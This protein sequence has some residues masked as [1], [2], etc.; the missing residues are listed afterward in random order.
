MF[1]PRVM[2]RIKA[3]LGEGFGW[4]AMLMAIIYQSVRLLPAGHPYTNP[5]NKGRF[6]VRHVIAEAAYNL[7]IK[8]E[9][10]D[11][12]VIFGI[13]LL[14]L[15]LL[16]LQIIFLIV[17]MMIAPAFAGF[18]AGIPGF[19]GLFATPNPTDDIAFMI[20]DQVFGIPG[21]YNSKFAPAAGAIPPFQVGLQTLFQYY[22][23]MILIV[24]VFI[25]LYYIVVTL[26]ETVTTGVPFGR[27]FNSIYAPF[28]LVLAIGLIVPLN[29]GM[30]C[31][32][33]ITLFS[34]KYGS[35]LATNGWILFANNVANPTDLRDEALLARP[36]L[37]NVNHI[38]KFMMIVQ[39]CRFAYEAYYNGTNAG[40]DIAN[41]P[42]A[43]P[44]PPPGPTPTPPPA[45]GPGIQPYYV[46]RLSSQLVPVPADWQAAVDFFNGE[47]IKIRFGHY[48]AANYE[49]HRGS[50]FPFCGEITVHTTSNDGVAGVTTGAEDLQQQFLRMIT[51]LWA[52]P[53]MQDFGERAT[54]AFLPI[55]GLPDPCSVD[56][57]SYGEA[58][59]VTTNPR[60]PPEEYKASMYTT[61]RNIFLGQVDS[62]YTASTS[63]AYAPAY[64]V[65]PALLDRGWGG[66]AIWYNHIAE[67]NGAFTAAAMNVPTPSKMPAVMEVVEEA[68]N[69]NDEAVDPE[70]RFRPRLSGGQTV[71]F[72]YGGEESIAYVLNEAYQY[73]SSGEDGEFTDT[74]QSGNI[75]IAALTAVFGLNG[76]FDLRDNPDT[77]P[78]A[79]LVGA[80]KA[81]IESAIGNLMVG[82]GLAVGGGVAGAL[83]QHMGGFIVAASHMFVSFASIGITVGF[84]LYY[85]LPFL[86]FMYFFFAVG[87]WVKSIFEALVGVPLWALA[88]L[89][90]DGNGIPGDSASG[91][92]FLIF[93][94]FIRPILTVFGLLGGM[95]IFSAMMRVLHDIFPLV[96][97][98]LTGFDGEID[99]KLGIIAGI[100]LKRDIVDE[101]MFT[102]VYTI[103]AYM[104][105]TSSFKM[106]DQVPNS[107][108]R[109]MGAGVQSFSDNNESAVQGLVQYAGIGGYQMSTQITGAMQTGAEGAGRVG[110]AL[111][112]LGTRAGRG[113]GS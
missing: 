9:N 15:V 71:E 33:Y 48:D 19:I 103:I 109:W 1:M 45:Y 14:G 72:T 54:Y 89:R 96:V 81:I 67:W 30:N 106:I 66:A 100:E 85:I 69:T 92:Y 82:M 95:A 41:T 104:I 38:T 56:F 53:L 11:Q 4:I 80:G 57:S 94:I 77:H 39:A 93:E 13:I 58:G 16:A 20:L 36:T 23:M 60:M 51:F 18:G 98:N 17:N 7:E 44:P 87:T 35:S 74:Q 31:A 3:L 64:A 29:Y 34:A 90:I 97:S 76:L 27:R 83:N 73:W 113:T 102:I 70:N 25:F 5:A 8:K 37:P 99:P 108:L 12:V 52:S 42:T 110:G 28:R 68:R 49:N 10:I 24:A 88:H 65:P 101:F 50:V 55:T 107:I 86:P 32:Q 40:P 63:G 43:P 111:F 84:I 79:A 6:G 59:C 46:N 75:I 2:P 78:L 61:R 112:G 47:D 91:G 22:S 105:A 21:L 62:A 26:G